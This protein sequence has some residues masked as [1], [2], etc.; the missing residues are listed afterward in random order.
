M[1]NECFIRPLHSTYI[2]EHYAR[3][4][5]LGV[6]VITAILAPRHVI[7]R[8]LFVRTELEISEPHIADENGIHI[9]VQNKIICESY[10]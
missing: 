3:V 9:T 10:D 8:K 1:L 6:V 5:K 7:L 4:N 2:V